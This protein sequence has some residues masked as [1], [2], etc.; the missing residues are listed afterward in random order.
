[1]SATGH[2][3]LSFVTSGEMTRRSTT[4]T[5]SSL[6]VGETAEAKD[7]GFVVELVMPAVAANGLDSL[8]APLATTKSPKVPAKTAAYR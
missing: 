7:V 5:R 8:V 2:Q 1:M 6:P 4:I 3:V